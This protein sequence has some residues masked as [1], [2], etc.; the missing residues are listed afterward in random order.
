M[1]RWYFWVGLAV[2]A[3]FLYFA[4]RGLRLDEVWGA[5]SNA[6]LIWLLPGIMVYFTAVL[7][8][9]WRWQFLLRPVR[10]I[11]LAGMFPV[12]A[13]G[14]MGNNIYPA[15]AGELLSAL[16]L[17]RRHQVP[18]SASLATIL[19][20]RI[21]DGVVMLSFLFFN[22]FQLSRFA[23]Q[24]TFIDLLRSLAFWGSVIFIGLLAIFLAMASFPQ[25]ADRVLTYITNIILPGKWRPGAQHI[26]QRFI[27]G[28]GAL[29][30][31]ADVLIVFA[32]SIGIW[33]IE[34]C[35]Y[36]FVMR[37]FPF[38]VSFFTLMLLLGVVN[39]AT[40]LPSAPGYIGT[41]DAMSI[42]FLTAVGVSPALSAGFTLLLH[43]ALWLPVTVVGLIYFAREGLSWSMDVAG[44]PSEQELQS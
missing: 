13:I 40:T 21:F 33:L 5:I 36:W 19:V 32:A 20:E 41:F 26:I 38:S 34:T 8:R 6:H 4:L 9:A 30:S 43:A 24:S 22:L 27:Q 10:S 23:A 29:R 44:S 18:V 17:K 42:A 14:Y 35:F 37:A 2:S 3:L 12:V 7:A 16:V 25:K 28:F 31:P 39:L 11:S 15:R 1:K